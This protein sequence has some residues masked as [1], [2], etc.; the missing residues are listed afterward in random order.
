MIVLFPWAAIEELHG[1][2]EQFSAHDS[3]QTA[4]NTCDYRRFRFPSETQ[5]LYTANSLDTSRFQALL[6]LGRATNTPLT[7]VTG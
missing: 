3:F 4:L 5:G 6:G 7:K 2:A 1:L